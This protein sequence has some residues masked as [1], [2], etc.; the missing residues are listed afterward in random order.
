MAKSK[1]TAGKISIDGLRTLINKTSGVNV[2][3]NLKE[4]NPTEVKEWI[5]TGSRWLDSIVCRGKLGGIPIGK[6]TEIAG[7]ESTGKSFMAAQ[8]AANA[9][10]MGMTVVYMDSE[11]AIDPGFLERTGCN[12]DDLIYV[13]AQS[14]EHVL[15]TVESVL[16]SGAERT[17]FIWDSLA[18]TPTVSDVTFINVPNP[19]A[20][21]KS[22]FLV[23]NQLKTNI[24]QGPNAR[25]IAMTTPYITPG[26]KAM[27]Y[28]YSLRIWLTGR[29]AKSA[30]IEDESGF[31]IGS[32]VKVRLEK[33]RFGTQGRNCAFKILWGTEEVGIQDAESWL[34]A[35]K[36]SDNLKQA[37]AWFSLVHKDG[38]EEK[39]QSAHWIEKLEDKKFKTRV[40][41]IMDEQI[42]RKF[43]DRVGSFID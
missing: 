37:G 22:A 2:A 32:E 9:Q 13:Q 25:I 38:K 7:L 43:N 42:I 31:R 40:L 12:L 10:R 34:E 17:L 18:L 35:I 14:V 20:N 8:C 1:S 41:E 24:P 3:H 16:N 33:S 36:G 27:H 28:V 19:I 30:F 4:A 23:L 39:F 26:G 15:E 5:P 29:K 21:T 11:S 6:F